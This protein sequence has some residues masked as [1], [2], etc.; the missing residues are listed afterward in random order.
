MF[1]AGAQGNLR[2]RGAM[3]TTTCGEPPL[4]LLGIRCG[5]VGNAWRDERPKEQADAC[6]TVEV[7]MRDSRAESMGV[8]RSSARVGRAPHGT[9]TAVSVSFNVEPS[10]ITIAGVRWT[11]FLT[12]LHS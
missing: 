1:Y 2:R 3:C 5:P 6:G 9:G 8:R 7:G 4:T 12:R 10:N 11:K